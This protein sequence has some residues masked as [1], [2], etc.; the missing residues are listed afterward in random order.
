MY[1]RNREKIIYITWQP[2]CSRSDNTA[3]ELGGRSYI[4]Y[5][6]LLGSNYYTIWI[7]YLLQA[8][9]TFF[10]LIKDRP[11]FIF[12]MSPP[13]FAIFPVFIYCKLVKK[14]YI[15]DAHTGAFIDDMWQKVMFLQKFFCKYAEFT[16]VTNDE[17]AKIVESWH[18]KSLVIP[19]VPIK[20]PDPVPPPMDN[21]I[22]MILVN[23][24]ALDEPLDEF[25]KAVERFPEIQF[26]VTG[27][28]NKRARKYLN[29]CPL[30][31]VF[32]DFLP[33]PQYHGLL[34][35]SNFVVVLTT[36]DHTMQRG[37]Y[38]AI[39]HGKPV[40]TSNWP[41][42]RNNFPQGALF[43]DNTVEGIVEGIE[44]AIVQLSK[45]ELE[46]QDLMVKKI[47]DWNTHKEKI[48]SLL[49]NTNK[50]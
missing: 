40:I 35:K 32:T 26:Y 42:L 24:F 15:I 13:M 20:F 28:V 41:I 31:T 3:R 43:V 48:L 21:G 16:I 37:A 18:G 19:D 30:N 12:V 8:I 27:K 34:L 49:K 39:Y 7:K 2:Y 38:E 17:L 29:K 10:I 5:I 4:V 1:K 14:K 47:E 6:E 45:F 46:A 33:E 44:K 36:K 22:H 11:A 25:L 9:I 50:S 23:S